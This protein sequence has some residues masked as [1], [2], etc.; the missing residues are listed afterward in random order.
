MTAITQLIPAIMPPEKRRALI[1]DDNDHNLILLK[2]AMN[3]G[4]V[5]VVE[6]RTGESALTAGLGQTPFMFAFLDIVLPDISGLEV[7]RKLRQHDS[8]V[9][10]IMCSTND[11]PE[12][13]TT[14]VEAGCDIY[15][16]KPYQ[17]DALLRMIKIMDRATLRSNPNVLVIDNTGR[18]RWVKR[19]PNV[20]PTT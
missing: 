10:I 20:G 18:Y 5:E 14:A 19:K 16:V 9:G 12:T 7:A 8:N 4:N 11:D 15:L 17:L 6:A 1:L 2:F 13:I 3:M